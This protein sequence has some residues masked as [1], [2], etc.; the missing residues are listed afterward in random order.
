[1]VI[2]FKEIAWM[3]DGIVPTVDVDDL[4]SIWSLPEVR[5]HFTNCM[6]DLR[7]ANQK[8]S[9]FSVGKFKSVCSHGSNAMAALHRAKENKSV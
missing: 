4:K 5:E 8:P 2:D 3:I 1:M 6:P 7:S 9:V